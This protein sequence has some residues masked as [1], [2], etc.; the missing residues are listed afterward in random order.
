R[1]VF[2][3]RAGG[4]GRLTWLVRETA[5][6]WQVR[7]AAAAEKGEWLDIGPMRNPYSARR[8]IVIAPLA[9]KDE[10]WVSRMRNV[11]AARVRA[12]E[13]GRLTIELVDLL[14]PAE[15]EIVAPR[16]PKSVEGADRWR[17]ENGCIIASASKPATLEIDPA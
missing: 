3:A 11:N 13:T 1:G 8:E 9:A 5:P 6:R 15:I 2:E 17:F 10:V 16:S 12:S 14:G 7:N 4:A